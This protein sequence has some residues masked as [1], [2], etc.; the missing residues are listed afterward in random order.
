ML[1]AAR[2]ISKLDL[3]VDKNIIAAVEKLKS[4]LNVASKERISDEFSKLLLLESPRKGLEFLVQTKLAE[5]FLPELPALQLEVD[6]HHRHKDVY[7]HTLIVLEQAIDLE[8][9][10]EP[11]L[12]PDL[13]LRIEIL[14]L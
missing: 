1:R 12:A 13:V 9:S 5:E 2:F 4:R 11:Q 14:I 7:H 3:V 10:H 6:E 8:K